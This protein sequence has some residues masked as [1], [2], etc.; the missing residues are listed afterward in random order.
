MAEVLVLMH[1]EELEAWVYE[2]QYLLAVLSMLPVMSVL[3]Y[4]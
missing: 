2:N 3:K 1:I 4:H